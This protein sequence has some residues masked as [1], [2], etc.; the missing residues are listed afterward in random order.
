V[1]WIDDKGQEQMQGS[2]PDKG[3]S[4]LTLLPGQ[5]G[6]ENTYLGHIW[7]VKNV[8]GRCVA[9]LKSLSKHSTATINH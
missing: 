7:I 4:F 5:S 6:T 8:S 9:I 2:G 3:K 1:N